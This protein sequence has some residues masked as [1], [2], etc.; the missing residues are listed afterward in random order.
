MLSK[1]MRTQA[2]IGDTLAL[3]WPRRGLAAARESG[4]GDTERPAARDAGAPAAVDFSDLFDR[5]QKRIFNLLY[6]LVGDYDDAADLTSETFVLALKAQGQFRGESQTYTWLYRIAVNLAK[7]HYRRQSRRDGAQAR[8]LDAAGDEPEEARELP[9]WSHTPQ[10]MLE[11]R[12]L[13]AVVHQAIQALPEEARL[14]VVLRDLQGLSYQEMAE[15]LDTTA[16]IVK[17]RL[18]RARSALRKRLAP[19]LLPEA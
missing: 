2:V 1:L 6:R 19:Y 9:D 10:K 3:P 4:R 14:V 16:E 13:Q 15:V 7:N 12:E 11:A 8:S 5:Y 18:F 17:A